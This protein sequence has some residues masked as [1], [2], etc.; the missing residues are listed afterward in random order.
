[1]K[2]AEA[3]RSPLPPETPEERAR[4]DE[5]LRGSAGFPLSD[6]ADDPEPTP[7]RKPA[8]M[9]PDIL[10]PTDTRVDYTD[11]DG[12]R[13][14]LRFPP[15]EMQ[16]IVEGLAAT[17]ARDAVITGTVNGRRETMPVNPVPAGAK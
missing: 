2:R 9:P 14:T 13:Q 5:L 8:M 16:T 6:Q 15:E 3:R 4:L 1:M 7:T 11:A 10:A 12:V 17:G